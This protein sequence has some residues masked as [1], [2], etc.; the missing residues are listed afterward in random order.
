MAVVA[1]GVHHPLMLGGKIH[2]G[3]FHYAQAVHV[4][5]DGDGLIQPVQAWDKQDN[6]GIAD[7]LRGIAQLFKVIHNKRLGFTLIKA[8]FRNFM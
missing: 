6:A 1:A 7:L 5:A 2:P 4:G 3:F 8:R